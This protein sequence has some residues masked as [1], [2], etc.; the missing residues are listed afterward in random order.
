MASR[1]SQRDPRALR[2]KVD[3][4]VP[5][6]PDL[7]AMI[8]ER[9]YLPFD[10]ARRAAYVT[11]TGV[12]AAKLR[13]FVASSSTRHLGDIAGIVRVQGGPV[14]G[15]PVGAARGAVGCFGVWRGIWQ[16]NRG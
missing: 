16:A 13:A 3:F 11:A 12:V 7:L 14:G 1:A 5:V 4:Y 15:T 2:N 6:E 9:V 10:E 8:A